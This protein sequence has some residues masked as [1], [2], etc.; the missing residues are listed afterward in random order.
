MMGKISGYLDKKELKNKS[1]YDDDVIKYFETL[2]DFDEFDGE[3]LQIT[4]DV[5]NKVINIQIN[6]FEIEV[7]ESKVNEEWKGYE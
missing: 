5:T 3:Y 4:H 1:K 7:P 6:G 2:I